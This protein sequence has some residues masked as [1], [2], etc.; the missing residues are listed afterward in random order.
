MKTIYILLT[1]SGTLLSNLVFLL[2]GDPFTHASISFDP[3]LQPLYSSARK[4]GETMFPAGP[5][6]EHFHRGFYK[7]HR[8]I[9]CA[10]YAFRVPEEQYHLAKMEVDQIIGCSDEY[11]FNILGL[12]LCRM[13]IPMQRKKKFF[14]SQFVAEIL[15]RSRALELPKVPSLMRPMDYTRLSQMTCLFQGQLQEL[16][17]LRSGIADTEEPL[18]TPSA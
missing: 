12:L 2:T 10:L 7:K 11:Q 3:S 16:V 18:L 1:R 9:P 14:C 17:T 6:R 5:C 8:N 13:N 15:T 4:N